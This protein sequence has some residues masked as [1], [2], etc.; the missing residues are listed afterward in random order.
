[1]AA[2]PPH[3]LEVARLLHQHSDAPSRGLPVN[4]EDG[5]DTELY[6]R[7]VE[8]MVAQYFQRL[9]QMTGEPSLLPP[10]WPDAGVH[11][12]GSPSEAA[13]HRPPHSGPEPPATPP[14]PAAIHHHGASGAQALSSAGAAGTSGVPPP[15]DLPQ[16]LSRQHQAPPRD[17]PL[18]IQQHSPVSREAATGGFGSGNWQDLSSSQLS[19]EGRLHDPRGVALFQ[20][21]MQWKARADMETG[22]KQQEARCQEAAECS[23]QPQVNGKP[24]SRS[25]VPATTRLYAMGRE[26]QREKEE[27]C[28]QYEDW[29]VWSQCTFQP[30]T[31]TELNRALHAKPKYNRPATP[32][33]TS[34]PAEDT[35]QCT[36]R[37][38]VNALPQEFRMA[39]SYL[40]QPAHQRLFAESRKPAPTPWA[41]QDHSRPAQ[42]PAKLQYYKQ[43]HARAEQEIA[44]LEQMI[45]GAAKALAQPQR[46]GDAM[47]SLSPHRSPPRGALRRP[48]S[49]HRTPTE[50]WHAAERSALFMDQ[51]GN[52]YADFQA[53]PGTLA[54]DMVLDSGAELFTRLDPPPAWRYDTLRYEVDG[55]I[56]D[57]NYESS[58]EAEEEPPDVQ[59]SPRSPPSGVVN[60]AA[61]L[62]RQNA[63]EQKRQE[64]LEKLRTQSQDPHHPRLNRKSVKLLG[65]VSQ[66]SDFLGRQVGHQRRHD[67]E[68]S[69]LTKAMAKELT[70]EPDINPRSKALSARGPVEFVFKDAERLQKRKEKLAKYYTDQAARDTTFHPK[71][72][73]G[74]GPATGR[75]RFGEGLKGYSRF[76]KAQEERRETQRQAVQKKLEREELKHCTFQ[77]QTVEL[78]AYI[79]RLAQS[80]SSLR[81]STT[82]AELSS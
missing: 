64:E 34:S 21:L 53:L 58:E 28:R 2:F 7:Q 33:V 46:T 79:K 41:C 6:I 71:V 17:E 30:E 57:T 54:A 60:F 8:G 62:E 16:W 32:K 9:Q 80:L 26:R 24:L 12:D 65:K 61:F 39:Q 78:P 70:F 22:Q 59:H 43:L 50:V 36:F 66:E 73:A 56:V 51:E 69:Q 3:H 13:T 68:L 4:F 44:S 20:R 72:N 63:L 5:I 82:S 77:P 38:T 47:Q 55:R 37:P 49:P 14:P 1:M 75:L 23:F 76:L 31:N 11:A 27:N 10:K 74:A 52:Y 25:Q 48:N 29:K 42:S 35:S 40:E 18:I 19:Q 15:T 45:A 81:D 67:K